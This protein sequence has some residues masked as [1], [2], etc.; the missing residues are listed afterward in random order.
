MEFIFELIFEIIIE[1]L[2]YKKIKPW[3][4]Y[5]ILAIIM[6]LYIILGAMLTYFAFG[7][8]KMYVMKIIAIALNVLIIVFFI[9][10]LKKTKGV[11]EVYKKTIFIDID[12][13][14]KDLEQE[15]SLKNINAI[16][17]A[18][19]RGHRIILASGRPYEFVRDVAK[20]VGADNLLIASN[21]A[22]IINFKTNEI[23]FQNVLDEDIIR[24]FY[25]LAKEYKLNL[26]FNTPKKRFSTFYNKDCAEITENNIESIIKQNKISQIVIVHPKF[27]VMKLVR[28]KIKTLNNINITN[29]SKSLTENKESAEY[30]YIDISSKNISKGN[31]ILRLLDYLNI[32][33][34]N[35]IAIG[36][37]YN[38]ISMAE[39]VETFVAV[40][41][42]VAEL[43]Q[44][45]HHITSSCLDDGVAKY[46]DNL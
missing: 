45:S 34:K 27:E 10:M 32:E 14:L 46:L 30:Y 7:A 38:D 18:K 15:I 24:D 41:N 6:T 42:A 31:A 12:L 22:E 40:D 16:K 3:I 8:K 1:L 36:D 23:I 5:T 13:T 28:K 39:V 19:L 2:S 9:K 4:R 44:K 35:T 11:D 26:F 20:M 33:N 17:N 37:S 43:K 29:E 25:N 21:G